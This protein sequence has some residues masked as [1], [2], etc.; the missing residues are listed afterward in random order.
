MRLKNWIQQSHRY[1]TTVYQCEHCGAERTTSGEVTDA[2]MDAAMLTVAGHPDHP[3]DILPEVMFTALSAALAVAPPDADRPWEPLNGR[4]VRVGEEIRRDRCGITSIAVVGRVD[5]DGDP[6]TAEGALI[7]L[8]KHGTWYVRRTVQELPTDPGSVIVPADGHEH[9]TATVGGVTYHAR[10]AILVGG[11][12]WL[13]SWRSGD[14]V[15][16]HIEEVSITPGI[17][18]VAGK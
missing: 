7:G 17:W 1:F 4:P 5:D 6:W 15:R 2:M 9:I 13:G 16:A 10:E 11:R 12:V 3:V 8:L 14:R 18:K